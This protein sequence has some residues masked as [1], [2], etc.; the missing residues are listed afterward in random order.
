MAEP[1]AWATIEK[2]QMFIRRRTVRMTGFWI[3]GGAAIAFL[4]EL[5]GMDS[6]SKRGYNE[7]MTQ[8]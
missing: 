1:E 2:A 7:A 6:A 4:L 3:L 5:W 8:A